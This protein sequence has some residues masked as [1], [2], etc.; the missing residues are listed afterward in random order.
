[1]TGTA[2]DVPAQ[3]APQASSTKNEQ[4]GMPLLNMTSILAGTER[5]TRDKLGPPGDSRKRRASGVVQE[6]VERINNLTAKKKVM[7]TNSTVKQMVAVMDD[8]AK[9]AMAQVT[10]ARKYKQ[11]KRVLRREIEMG[12]QPRILGFLSDVDQRGPLPGGQDGLGGRGGG[13]CPT[14]TSRERSSSDFNVE[15]CGNSQKKRRKL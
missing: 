5:V 14:S 10:P 15:S 6:E 13:G 2:V 11:G 8:K 4:P 9:L 1:M 12:I 3:G 7:K